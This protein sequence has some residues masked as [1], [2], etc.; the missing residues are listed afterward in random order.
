MKIVIKSSQPKRSS[1]FSAF[2]E[3]WM[4]GSHINATIECV[5]K[6]GRSYAGLVFD[7]MEHVTIEDMTVY[8]CGT[9]SS[10]S[11][12]KWHSSEHIR[13]AVHAIDIGTL[14]VRKTHVLESSGTGIVIIL[15]NQSSVVNISHCQFFFFFLETRFQRRMFHSIWVEK[16]YTCVCGTQVITDLLFMNACFKTT[17]QSNC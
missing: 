4:K 3:I 13:S 17:D 2:G 6:E 1:L 16:E 8:R 15:G 14:V 9:F 10:K 7:A 12:R 5:S 11:I